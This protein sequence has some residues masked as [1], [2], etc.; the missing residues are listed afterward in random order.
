MHLQI[1]QRRK[2]IQSSVYQ[3][4]DLH[5]SYL[6]HHELKRPEQKDVK[7]LPIEESREKILHMAAYHQTYLERVK[8]CQI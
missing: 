2:E 3:R 5:K 1:D 4:I 7:G 6:P 8:R